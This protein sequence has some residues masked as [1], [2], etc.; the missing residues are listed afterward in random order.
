MKKNVFLSLALVV[1]LVACQKNETLV[2]ESSSDVVRSSATAATIYSNNFEA[3]PT[4]WSVYVWSWSTAY[5]ITYA[6]SKRLDQAN[7]LAKVRTNVYAPVIYSTASAITFPGIGDYTISYSTITTATT[8][9][10]ASIQL[11]LV[12]AYTSTETIIDTVPLTSTATPLKTR[13]AKVS[14][15]STNPQFLRV[16]SS[17]ANTTIPTQ[18]G[19]CYIDDIVIQ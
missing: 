12:D 3:T 13:T 15:S 7:L 11:K 19:H 1:S 8:I 10:N 4:G 14:V 16:V 9:A 18:A 6:A 2:P 5:A 17:G